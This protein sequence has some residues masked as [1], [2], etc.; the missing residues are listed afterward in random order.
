MKELLK[1]LGDAT[2]RTVTAVQMFGCLRE[3][4]AIVFGDGTYLVIGVDRGYG[5][6]FEL[7]AGELYEGELY[8]DKG[9]EIGLVSV[10]DIE[11]HKEAK[12]QENQRR[13]AWLESLERKQY[14]ELRRK[15]SNPEG[16]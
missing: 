3:R 7:V 12:E 1:S 10:A 9:L 4:L 11:A 13:I 15:Y 8:S 6:D 2:G 5:G 16:K 14:E